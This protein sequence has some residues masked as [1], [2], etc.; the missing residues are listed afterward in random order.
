MARALRAARYIRVSKEEQR[1]GLQFDETED[2]IA[3]RGWELVET[4]HDQG[5][6]GS[7][8]RRPQLDNLLTWA[9]SRRIDVI[10]V[11]KADRL[12]RNLHH[13]LNV[14]AE[15]DALGVAF[16]SCT[17][18][19]DTTTPSGKLLF[20]VV[21]AMGQFERD[22]LIERTKS[23]L[24][25]ARRRGKSLGR[26]RKRYDLDAAAE[27]RAEG[28]TLH[29][30]AGY[31]GVSESTLCRALKSRGTPSTQAEIQGAG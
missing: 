17:E 7:R 19:F 8:D 22:L 15:L 20:H 25:A 10:V 18:P 12:F 11:Y 14:L 13:M 1:P 9:R 4:F 5:I 30:V 28:K 29:D 26:P 31:F 24:A 23:G 16:V 3:R 2:F 6:S 21:A 27:M